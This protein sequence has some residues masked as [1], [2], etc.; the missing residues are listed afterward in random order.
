MWA[1]VGGGVHSPGLVG[2]GGKTTLARW[3]GS[4]WTS[5]ATLPAAIAGFAPRGPTDVWAMGRGAN[6]EPVI[7]HWD[8]RR[9]EDIGGEVPATVTTGLTS[10]SVAA[11]GAVVGFGSDYPRALGGGF[12]G[13]WSTANNY[14]WISCA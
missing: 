9:W 12:R 4:S 2:A 7:R 8:G 13:S 11:S 5:S 3:D 1:A 14:L 10:V 6:F